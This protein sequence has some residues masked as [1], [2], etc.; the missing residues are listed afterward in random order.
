MARRS[1]LVTL[2]TLAVGFGSS[3]IGALD[4]SASLS[5]SSSSILGAALPEQPTILFIVTDDQR[6]DTLDGMPKT[7]RR[8]AGA[9]VEFRNGFVVNPICCPSRASLLTGAYS[10][11]TGVY[12]N[13]PPHGGFDAFDDSSTLPVWLSE[14]GYKTGLFGKY[15]NGYRHY[16][17]G[18]YVPPGWSRWVHGQGYYNYDLNVDGK[19]EHR[20]DAPRDYLTDVITNYAVRWIKNTEGPL[21]AYFAPSAPHQP[22]TPAP[23]HVGSA[24]PSWVKRPNYNERD[25]SDK[26][27]W[28]RA[29]PALTS[30]RENE[31]RA[32]RAQQYRSLRAVDEAVDRLL[33]ALRETGR[34][35][36]TFIAFIS[37]NGLGWGE[38]R[39]DR[40]QVAYEES[41]RVPFLVRFDPLVA[42]PRVD[43]NLVL[44]IDLAVTAA[45]LAGAASPGAEGRSLLPL[46]RSQDSSWRSTFLIE[47]LVIARVPSYCA[48]RSKRFLYAYYETGEKELYDLSTDPYEMRNR[49][50]DPTLRDKRRQLHDRLV[51]MC[52]PPPPGMTFP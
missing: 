31:I 7:R 40:K 5:R 29:L 4:A 12:S 51:D 19:L 41:I 52:R 20:G 42:A 9:G 44:N 2:V 22:A 23:R 46:L 1:V 33:D 30:T 45:R 39:W 26:P 10:H 27:A 8:L 35:S 32:L 18:T 16:G 6:W 34:L 21:F 50:S 28:V 17:D 14:A 48:V 36:T 24:V 47:H 3:G 37:D 49:A 13:K 15:M 11:T 25:V 38:H 43:D